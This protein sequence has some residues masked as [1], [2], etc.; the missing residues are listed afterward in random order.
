MNCF[1]L[2]PDLFPMSFTPAP[3]D[4]NFPSKLPAIQAFLKESICRGTWAASQGISNSSCLKSSFS[5]QFSYLKKKM[6][7]IIIWLSVFQARNV[8]CH[9]L[10]PA[11]LSSLVLPP[12]YL[13]V[14]GT[15][16]HSLGTAFAE[17]LISC[18][19]DYYTSLSA[20][21]IIVSVQFIL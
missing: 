1:S 21:S 16:F 13:L 6:F 4:G 10:L 12:S 9:F 14:I 18:Y 20:V 7:S 11:S 3:W 17:A 5:S 15:Q 8:L 19:L 2:F